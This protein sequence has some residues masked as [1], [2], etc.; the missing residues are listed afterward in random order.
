MFNSIYLKSSKSTHFSLIKIITLENLYFLIWKDNVPLKHNFDNYQTEWSLIKNIWT[1][2]TSVELKNVTRI[3]KIH[4]TW[5]FSHSVF[6]YYKLHFKKRFSL[7]FYCIF[8]YNY[9]IF[10]YYKIQPHIFSIV[11]L[12]F[13]FKLF[14]LPLIL[15][16]FQF[17]SRKYRRIRTI[18]SVLRICLANVINRRSNLLN[19]IGIGF[20]SLL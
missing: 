19:C 6:K 7:L 17:Q 8:Y 5:K 11:S 12:Y 1:I 10:K 3:I 2:F 13:L 16:E 4:F 14:S 20:W 15:N 18:V 9:F